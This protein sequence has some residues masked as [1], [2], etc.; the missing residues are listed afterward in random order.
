[1]TANR[2][3]CPFCNGNNDSCPSCDGG[4]IT[5][6]EPIVVPLKP[7]AMIVDPQDRVADKG[8]SGFRPHSRK[9]SLGPPPEAKGFSL[10]ALTIAAKAIA[11]IEKDRER[12]N[13]AYFNAAD[14]AFKIIKE[15]IGQNKNEA[16]KPRLKKL[17]DTAYYHRK[18]AQSL[19]RSRVALNEA[20][21]SKM[22]SISGAGGREQ[23]L[24]R[25]PS[26]VPTKGPTL[27]EIRLAEVVTKQSKK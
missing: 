8:S 2:R 22:L 15:L 6:G 9:I 19:E 10:Q 11:V 3:L 18:Q 20:A 1:M 21:T 27:M 17:L 16:M 14:S 24:K 23:K 25:N 12:S 4:W 13:R 5:D 26:A 7:V